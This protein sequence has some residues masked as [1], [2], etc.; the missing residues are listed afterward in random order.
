M[1]VYLRVERGVVPEDY[2]LVHFVDFPD[3]AGR[4][5]LEWPWPLVA[6]CGYTFMPGRFEELR[7]AGDLWCPIC[8]QLSPHPVR[9]GRL[10]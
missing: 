10:T 5:V 9:L 7:H 6:L 3:D 1:I 8:F 4:P 2:R